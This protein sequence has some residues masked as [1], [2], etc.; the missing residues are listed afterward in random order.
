MVR[1]R[2]SVRVIIVCDTTLECAQFFCKRDGK[3]IRQEWFSEKIR[4]HE[5]HANL[6]TAHQRT[7]ERS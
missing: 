3:G 2:V 1:V 4:L 7:L 6:N 5:L